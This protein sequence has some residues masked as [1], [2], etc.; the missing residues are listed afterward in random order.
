[1][2]QTVSK[3]SGRHRKGKVSWRWIPIGEYHAD[4]KDSFTKKYAVRL[5]SA[6]GSKL[7]MY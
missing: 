2:S 4:R 1:M 7:R 6:A 3:D 5:N